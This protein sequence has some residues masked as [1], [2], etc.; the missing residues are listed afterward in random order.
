MQRE[1]L[2]IN[3]PKKRTN[4]GG[5]R[6]SPR[7]GDGKH[8]ILYTLFFLCIGGGCGEIYCNLLA[9]SISRG[10]GTTGHLFVSR[11]T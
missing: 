3:H 6:Q 2:R 7:L 9:E 5:N 1:F 11:G 10:S 8:N 4:N